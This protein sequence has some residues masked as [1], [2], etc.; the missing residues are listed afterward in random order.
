M[1]KWLSTGALAAIT[2]AIALTGGE[3][4]AGGR[5][6]FHHAPFYGFY[7]PGPQWLPPPRYY[8]Y[9]NEPEPDRFYQ[10][11]ESYYEPEYMGP[12]AE[13]VPQKPRKKRQP[14]ASL[15]DAVKKTAAAKATTA[16]SKP[17]SA[18]ALSCDKATAIVTGYGFA[19]VK[20][21]DC[22]G[23]VYAFNATRDGKTYAIKLSARS[24][25]LTEVKKL[26]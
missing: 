18:A 13:P 5:V 2:A 4:E 11:D 10:Y 8:Y 16:E 17:K 25:E 22:Q 14:A 26:Q 6:R 15:P 12:Y 24:G 21:E 7:Q 23:Q 19:T 9:F 3:A 20:A 1:L